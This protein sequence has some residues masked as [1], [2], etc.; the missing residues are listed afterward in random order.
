MTEEHAVTAPRNFIADEIAADIASGR[1]SRPLCTRFPPEPNGF[2]HIGHAM[3]SLTSYN[4][5]RSFGGLFNLRFDDTN[6]TMEEQRFVDAMIRDLEWLLETDLR[7]RIFHTSD[8]F[9]KLHACAV[10]LIEKDLAYV[11]DLG[12]EEIREYRGNFYV[13]GR[14]SPWRDRPIEENL[15]LF[16]EMYEG[17]H[18][19]GS[20]VLRAKIDPASP[21]MNMRDPLIY[22]IF[23]A[24]H[25]RAGDWKIYP[26]Y[27]FAHPLSDAFEGI[28]HSICGKEF[29][30]H[31]PLYNW[32][33]EKLEFIEPPRQIEFAEINVSRT[34][35]SKRYLK[36]FIE[37]GIVNDWIDPRMPTISG[38]RRLGYPAKSI[39]HFCEAIGVSKVSAGLVDRAFLDHFVRQNLDPTAPRA[40]GVVKPLKVVI[41]NYPADT[42]ETVEASN[43]PND[44][45]FGK[46]KIP[47]SREIYIDR[48]D[49]MEE[50]PSKFHRL[51]VG[52]E[53]RLRAAYIVRCTGM[54]KDE[55]TNEV[56][57]LR[58]TYDPDTKSGA[59]RQGPKVKGT[60][61]WVCSRSAIP[62]ELRLYEPL[63][64]EAFDDRDASKPMS[65]YI[66]PD[67]LTVLK[68]ALV[69]PGL[70]HVQP[71]QV[72]QLERVGYFCVDPDSTTGHLV[73]NRTIGLR[74]KKLKALSDNAQ[75]H[76]NK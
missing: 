54:V 33:L 7:D 27:D 16:R 65:D 72:I 70:A 49:F 51:A 4:L 29:E 21:N 40:M 2:M 15:N 10:K 37:D 23:F 57:E 61:Q 59:K 64:I 67:S 74:D 52:R 32:F 48:D 69:E 75:A 42:T 8:Y 11:D 60:I 30:D 26:M 25:H 66:N 12:L 28:T 17:K 1:F 55:K 14:P 19:P 3:A 18:A 73:F 31:R 5:A 68:T 22:R 71:G 76:K 45:S 9:P 41:E 43:M 34:L 13:P 47:F 39:R 35:L 56:K 20:R 62:V 63:F 53:V 50:P 44:E 58:V 6:P 24:N 36:Q 38:M 46:R